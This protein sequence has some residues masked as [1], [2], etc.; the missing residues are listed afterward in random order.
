MATYLPGQLMT[1]FHQDLQTPQESQRK[2]RQRLLQAS[3]VNANLTNTAN[4]VTVKPGYLGY[5]FIMLYVSLCRN[6]SET[7]HLCMNKIKK[8]T[9][10]LKP[11]LTTTKTDLNPGIVP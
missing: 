5:K 2:R 11:K 4:Q 7:F 9:T 10:R 6:S 3:K 1:H 8:K